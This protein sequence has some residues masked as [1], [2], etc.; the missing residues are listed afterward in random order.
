MKRKSFD[1][2]KYVAVL[3]ITIVIFSMGMIVGHLLGSQ[4]ASLVSALQEDLRTDALD[5]ELAFSLIEQDPCEFANRA[6]VIAQIYDLGNRLDHME[7]V[8]GKNNQDVLRLKRYYSLLQ[9]RQWQFEK[10]VNEL[11]EDSRIPILY[12]YDN[13]PGACVGCDEQGFVL[14]YLRRK[15]DFV[16]V[17]SFD[18]GAE[19]E[20]LKALMA[21]YGVDQAP[22]IVVNGEVLRGFYGREPLEEII[23]SVHQRE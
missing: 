23:L 1:T 17:Y 22:T 18:M 21:R 20:S 6:P 4:K 10:R 5:I 7:S 15:F 16:S 8:L 12:F 2:K 19:S 3:V 11:C 9:I 14:T 13:S